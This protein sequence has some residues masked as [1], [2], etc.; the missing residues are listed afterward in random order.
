MGRDA[1]ALDVRLVD[2]LLRD[3]TE[4][5]EPAAE[6]DHTG[7]EPCPAEE[8][9]G[10]GVREPVHVE[11]H[12][13]ARDRDRD[14]DGSAGEQCAAVVV[15]PLGNEGPSVSATG[16]NVGR[17]RSNSSLMPFVRSH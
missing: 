6:R 7:C 12:A 14:S 1:A 9:S 10:D 4:L 11:K 15:W 3:L 2:R 13:S 8:E 17:T 5:E 16:F